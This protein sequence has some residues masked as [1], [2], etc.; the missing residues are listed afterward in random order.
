[1]K[2]GEE[3]PAAL[4]ITLARIGPK[5][6]SAK[7]IKKCGE[8]VSV[9]ASRLGEPQTVVPFRLRRPTQTRVHALALAALKER[10][11]DCGLCLRG[12]G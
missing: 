11:R 8:K 12:R 6:R 7:A 10:C 9:L 3:A 5:N 2:V 1:M 4:L